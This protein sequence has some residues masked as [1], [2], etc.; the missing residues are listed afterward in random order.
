MY[1]RLVWW[2]CSDCLLHFKEG[3]AL[4]GGPHLIF[5]CVLP[6]QIRVI[7]LWRANLHHVVLTEET[8]PYNGRALCFHICLCILL[9]L[10]TMM[11]LCEFEFVR[12]REKECPH[13]PCVCVCICVRVHG[14]SSLCV[15]AF[16]RERKSAT[17]RE[18]ERESVC[19]LLLV[20]NHW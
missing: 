2:G 8:H 9:V 11:A 20:S 13:A 7:F 3:W 16:V 1:R 15:S 14:R 19:A 6:P 5:L 4:I 17:K 10:E 12:I 18:K